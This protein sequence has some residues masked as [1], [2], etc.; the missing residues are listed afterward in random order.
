MKR[1]ILLSIFSFVLNQTIFSG[2]C[3][4]SISLVTQEEMDNFETTFGCDSIYGDLFVGGTITNFDGLD[5]IKFVSGNIS[6]NLN[7]AVAFRMAS[8]T[9]CGDIYQNYS[10]GGIDMPMLKKM[11]HYGSYGSYLS[12]AYS[13][14]F[15]ELEEA[16]TIEIYYATMNSINTFQKLKRVNL[17]A[18]RYM[19]NLDSINGFDS[20]R[21][22]KDLTL[23]Y[24]AELKFIRNMPKIDTLENLTLI[25]SN[26]ENL[27]FM[28]NVKSF[29]VASISE[30]PMLKTT[31]NF[32]HVTKTNT[33]YL[34]LVPKLNN[35]GFT[36]LQSMGTAYVFDNDSLLSF[37]NFP[38]LKK[39]KDLYL[40]YCSNLQGITN[41]P[42]L[43][44]ITGEFNLHNNSMLSDISGLDQLQ[45]INSVNVV[46]NPLLNTCCIFA[47]LQNIGRLN[48]GLILENNGIDCS[49][50][51][52]LLTETCGDPDYDARGVSDNCDLRYNPGQADSDSDGIGDV[53]DNC[54][55]TAN[56]NQLDSDGDGI[57]DVC[58][59]TASAPKVEAQQADV[60]ISDNKRG[61]IM[62]TMAGSCYR[63]RID[64]SGN[65]YSMLINCP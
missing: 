50:V 13:I 65:L 56:N 18:F 43:T 14:S 4:V 9:S 27:N 62:K 5:N 59:T 38:S 55:M 11:G 12:G 37:G 10:A 15:P 51:V 23:M 36:A 19:T 47:D 31:N 53:C 54:L 3:N 2:V 41:M 45:F 6:M 20:L 46:D 32:P 63:I 33:I 29:D 26:L 44:A 42:Q 28:G 8:L 16:E 49:D 1:T 52:Q 57:G 21:Y 64:E 25:T 30:C 22:C 39:I 7:T 60:Y 40:S 24:N 61:V 34:G 48:S 17:I 58:D 35:F